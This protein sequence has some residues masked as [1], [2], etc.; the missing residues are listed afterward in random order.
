MRWNILI[1]VVVAVFSLYL[2]VPKASLF[3]VDSGRYADSARNLLETGKLLSKFTYATSLPL[4]PNG[5]P[6]NVPPVHTFSIALAFLFFGV[7]DY[8]VILVSSFWFIIGVIFT[9]LIAQRLFNTKVALLSGFVYVFTPQLLAYARDGATEPL[10][11]AELLMMTYFILLKRRGSLL[12]A[13]VV[14]GFAFFTKLQFGILVVPFLIWVWLLYGRRLLSV[15]SFF[16]PLLLMVVANKMG[17]LFSGYR[18]EALPVYLTF[19]QSSLYP[20]DDLPR[21][22]LSS[23]VNAS[24]FLSNLAVLVSKIFYN[25]YNFFKIIILDDHLLPSFIVPISTVLY[26]L[27]YINLWIKERDEVRLF[28]LLVLVL[29]SIS[30]GLSAV[31]SPSIRYIH[32]LLPFVIILGV[33]F[34]VEICTKFDLTRKQS[35]W[36]YVS[37]VTLF[38]VLPFLG[39]VILDRRFDYQHYQ[40]DKPYA[41]QVL[42]EQI[43]WLSAKDDIV[44]TNLDTWGSWYGNRRTILIPPTPEMISEIDG[45]HK[46]SKIFLTDYQRLNGD[47]PLDKGWDSLFDQTKIVP[48]YVTTH[49]TLERTATISAEQVYEK[50]P[51]TYQVWSRK[52]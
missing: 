2:S 49:F 46:V 35:L 16:L 22:G 4:Y 20:G 5:W 52:Q 15:G 12:L 27:S 40:M 10:F 39:S 30:L 31:T 37:V 44:I 11:I 3:F 17:F 32:P 26:F 18:P 6:F 51:F 41:Q 36:I 38:W 28:R 50:Q 7:H 47:H 8:T 9:Y 42:G 21:S 43:G 1:L 23:S 13:G 45:R 19:Q 24:F 14:A 48:N 25:L 33:S 34:L 29:I